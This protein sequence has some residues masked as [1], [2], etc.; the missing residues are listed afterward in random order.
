MSLRK[1]KNTKARQSQ[2]EYLIVNPLRFAF[3]EVKFEIISFTLGKKSGLHREER[4]KE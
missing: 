3:S 1:Q 4:R 2:R